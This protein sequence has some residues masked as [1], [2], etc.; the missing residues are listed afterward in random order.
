MESELD[1]GGETPAFY[2]YALIKD[3]VGL[4]KKHDIFTYSTDLCWFW[5]VPFQETHKRRQLGER[6]A[7][8]AI[9]NLF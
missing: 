2:R 9:D 1:K 5:I 6:D 4:F 3:I 8:G 7:Y